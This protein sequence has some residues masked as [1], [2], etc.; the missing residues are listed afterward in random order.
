M[1]YRLPRITDSDL[2]QE[3]SDEPER[4]YSEDDFDP[5]FLRADLRRAA[6]HGVIELSTASEIFTFRLS[7]RERLRAGL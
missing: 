4:L 5:R 3:L 2:I 1:S 6:R 7:A